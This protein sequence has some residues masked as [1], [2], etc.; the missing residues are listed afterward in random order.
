MDDLGIWFLTIGA[1][2][3]CA[4]MVYTSLRLLKW[5]RKKIF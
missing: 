1:F 2:A 3:L 4:A 5:W